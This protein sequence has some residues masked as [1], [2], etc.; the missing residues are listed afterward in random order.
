MESHEIIYAICSEDENP[1]E[2]SLSELTLIDATR[3]AK[4]VRK[5]VYSFK[6]ISD[7]SES[8]I[9]KEFDFSLYVEI[10]TQNT[11]NKV[12]SLQRVID[13]LKSE[14]DSVGGKI[15]AETLLDQI[16]KTK[17]EL[18]HRDAERSLKTTEFVNNLFDIEKATTE[19]EQYFLDLIE[20]IQVLQ[21][22]FEGKR[23]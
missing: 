2:A 16:T 9:R 11:N 1:R 15:F 8:P 22:H 18:G 3:V 14:L 5:N 10:E 13:L 7:D 20:S 6:D 19:N 17:A 4:K 12:A 23:K 21:R